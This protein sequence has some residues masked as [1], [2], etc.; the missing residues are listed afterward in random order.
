MTTTV[1]ATTV[2]GKGA[3]EEAGERKKKK[4][5]RDGGKTLRGLFAVDPNVNNGLA[6]ESSEKRGDM[7]S[8]NTGNFFSECHVPAVFGTE[9]RT[10]LFHSS[11]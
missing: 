6:A 11:K 10:K 2:K 1:A 4:K 7:T 5:G 3:V 9:S 8:A